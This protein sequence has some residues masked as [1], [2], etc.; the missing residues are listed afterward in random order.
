M[1]S[2]YYRSHLGLGLGPVNQVKIVRYDLPS[3][4][5]G[6][7]AR[8]LSSSLPR[9]RGRSLVSLITFSSIDVK[10]FPIF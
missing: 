5:Y 9:I 10:K 3:Y 6:P 8:N 1:V 4:L 2:G 7:R